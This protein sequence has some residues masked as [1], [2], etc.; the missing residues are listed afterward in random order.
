MQRTREATGA[1]FRDF[2]SMNIVYFRTIPVLNYHG[3]EKGEGVVR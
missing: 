3:L 1:V 2:I